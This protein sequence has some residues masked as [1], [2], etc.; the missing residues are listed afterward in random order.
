[1]KFFILLNRD[2]PLGGGGL[3]RSENTLLKIFSWFIS[4]EIAMVKISL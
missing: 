2:L 1:V 4:D 3:C